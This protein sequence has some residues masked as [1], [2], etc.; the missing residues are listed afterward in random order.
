MVSK[1]SRHF[2]RCGQ[3]WAL[4]PEFSLPLP[5]IS[6][7]FSEIFARWNKKLQKIRPLPLPYL[8]V[9]PYV[10]NWMIMKGDISERYWS[11]PKTYNFHWNYKHYIQN[12]KLFC[13]HP[14]CKPINTSEQTC[15]LQQFCRWISIPIDFYPRITQFKRK[16]NTKFCI[17]WDNEKELLRYA[18]V[19]QFYNL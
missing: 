4:L 16:L 3:S 10:N 18:Y 11:H 19:L 14:E 6:R 2:I 9:C 15:C 7:P 5:G 13:F 8:S 1:N 12:R 17:L